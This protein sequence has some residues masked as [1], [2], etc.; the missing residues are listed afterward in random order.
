M[1]PWADW[2]MG[3]ASSHMAALEKVIALTGNTSTLSSHTTIP[4]PLLHLCW[5]LSVFFPGRRLAATSVLTEVVHALCAL[6]GA[7]R[8]EVR[9]VN[10]HHVTCFLAAQFLG[11]FLDVPVRLTVHDYYTFGD[12]HAGFMK[13]GSPDARF[14]R[15]IERYAYRHADFIIAVDTRIKGYVEREAHPVHRAVSVRL[16][17]LDTSDFAP[18]E[19]SVARAALEGGG[20]RLDHFLDGKTQLVL[21]PRRLSPKNGVNVLIR[22]AKIVASRSDRVQFLIAGEGIQRDEL[23]ALRAGLGLEDRVTFLGGV[24]PSLIRY[25]YN[26][27]DLVVIPSIT[28]EGIQ[29]ASSISALEA[30]ASGVPLIASAIGGLGELVVDGETGHLVPENNPEALAAT[31]LRVLA[32]DN[33]AI[34]ARARRQVEQA[35]SLESYARDLE[36]FLA[37]SAGRDRSRPS[38]MRVDA[39]T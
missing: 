1:A 7:V 18:R 8:S 39:R 3:G 35:H 37:A 19:K 20:L 9:L 10:P 15:R 23:L 2:E 31:I 34:T 12:V 21:C 16:N 33:S 6:P 36:A 38:P 25:L 13:A 14:A 28:I 30:M 11:R 22:A 27:V 5:F 26:V 4:E 29:E 24:V 17:F 32:E